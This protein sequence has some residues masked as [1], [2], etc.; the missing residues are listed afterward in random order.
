MK[1]GK[2]PDIDGITAEHYKNAV[3]KLLPLTLHILN[4][5]IEQLDI[6]KMLKGGI[7][8]PILKKN[9]DRQNPANY[10]GITV[11]KIFTKILQSVLKSRIDI[12]ISQIQNIF[13][14]DS[15]RTFP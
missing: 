9:K 13:R 2:S 1:P 8:T 15:Q 12:K 14:G 10:R 3:T 7:L 5:V 4:T 11:T 6:P